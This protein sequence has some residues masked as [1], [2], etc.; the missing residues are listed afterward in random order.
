MNNIRIER[1]L[2]HTIQDYIDSVSLIYLGVG[3]GM[4][5]YDF[6]VYEDEHYHITDTN[7]QQYP[8]FLHKFKGKQLIILCDPCLEDN[9]VIV[10]YFDRLKQPL[11]QINKIENIKEK[12]RIFE[13]DNI[14]VIAY[15]DKCNYDNH[16]S[17]TN[18]NYI[19]EKCNEK[20]IKFILQDFT[21]FDTTELYIKF[22][23]IHG[24]S[25]LNNILFDATQKDSG[26][27]VELKPEYASVDKN[28]NFIQEKYM[29]LSEIKELSEQ[30]SE[31]KDSNNE[32]NRIYK[33]R[34]SVLKYPLL[35]S[36]YDWSFKFYPDNYKLLYYIYDIDYKK[37]DS[38]KK[39]IQN[40][41][42]DILNFKKYD[43]ED[44]IENILK[45]NIDKNI[46]RTEFN[47]FLDNLL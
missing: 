3:T 4:E 14:I 1:T 46:T 18:I 12:I 43:S 20:Q 37:K 25:I 27:Y 7:N 13:N 44:L 38:I 31:L 40:L 28:N 10:R 16:D 11:K 21:G 33:A 17:I 41:L 15:N 32:L 35:W 22:L 47:K 2:W 42:I 5:K 45:M 26:C 36:L 24:K 30:L 19:I 29:K 8:I 39:L 34:V 6:D 23:E 9:L